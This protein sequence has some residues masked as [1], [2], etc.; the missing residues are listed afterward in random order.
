MRN[1][2]KE[3]ECVSGKKREVEGGGERQWNGKEYKHDLI[4]RTKGRK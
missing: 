4:R 3:K 2:G 1:E